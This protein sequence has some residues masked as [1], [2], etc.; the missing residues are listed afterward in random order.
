MVL[1]T[2]IWV[3]ASAIIQGISYYFPFFEVFE[4]IIPGRQLSELADLPQAET[5]SLAYIPLLQGL[6]LLIAGR[7]I[8]Q[9]TSL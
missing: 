8:M 1:A 3:L 2:L 4:L 6:A 5:L 9:R 7:F